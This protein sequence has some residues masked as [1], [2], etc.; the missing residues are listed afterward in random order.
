MPFLKKYKTIYFQLI[1]FGI[2]YFRF[3]KIIL[4]YFCAALLLLPIVMP[5]IALKYI[6]FF[7]KLLNLIGDII[8]D[9]L[10]ATIFYFIITPISF[11]K[12]MIEKK[13]NEA[14]IKSIDLKKMW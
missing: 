14:Q 12:R 10:F 2:L 9:I 3:E 1:G 13:T 5:K 6:L 7:E 4:L 11:I 8:K